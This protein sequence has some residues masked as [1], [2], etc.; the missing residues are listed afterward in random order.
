MTTAQN[1]NTNW[2]CTDNELGAALSITE[3]ISVTTAPET[4]AARQQLG[5]RV[6]GNNNSVWIFVQASTT[7]TAGN[8]VA[9]DVNFKA[10][11]MTGAFASSLRYTSGIAQFGGS[12]ILSSLTQQTAQPLD[13]FWAALQ[14][15]GLC[16]NCVTSAAAGVQLYVSGTAGSVMSTASSTNPILGLI[17]NTAFTASGSNTVTDMIAVEPIR[18]STSV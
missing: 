13:F 15:A 17:A 2:F 10:N 11:N 1:L 4:P 5:D 8:L 3:T 9:I 6:Q 18:A 14:G 12:T 16:V 7:V